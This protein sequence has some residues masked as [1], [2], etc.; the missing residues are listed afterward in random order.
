M[1]RAARMLSKVGQCI[2][3]L[4]SAFDVVN[5]LGSDY[6][7]RCILFHDVSDRRSAFT[8]GLKVTLDCAAF[9]QAISFV[10]EHYEPVTLD[11]FQAV[12]SGT[13]PAKPRVLVTFDDAYATVAENAAPICRKYGVPAVFFLNASLVDNQDLSLE[14][15]LTY[16]RNTQGLEPIRGV[17]ARVAAQYGLR[18]DGFERGFGRFVS[19]LNMQVRRQLRS[20]LTQ[21]TGLDTRELA[22]QAKL[23]VT[24]E[25]VRQLSGQGFEFGNH[26][27]SH[28]FGRTLE[29]ADFAD[30]IERNVTSI[31]EMTGAN[32]R[33]FSVPFGSSADLPASLADHLAATGHQTVFLVESL[34]NKTH[35]RGRPIYRVSVSART[36]GE[37]FSQLE[38]LPRLRTLGQ[39]L[40]TR[41]A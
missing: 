34:V 21:S 32:V 37:F 39:S 19:Q 8:E 13:A 31:T 20:L 1:N 5:V 4:P 25:Q 23:Y 17:A 30:E 18:R 11:H 29:T 6:G 15:F 41:N 40:R 12:D 38:F 7:V 36:P 3:K 16:V 24:S 27:Y 9:E 26:T 14:N 10:A 22:Q 35:L 28:V 33:A 2:W